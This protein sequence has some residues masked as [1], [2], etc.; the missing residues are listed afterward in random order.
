MS[1]LLSRARGNRAFASCVVAAAACLAAIPHVHA[2][3]EE[4]A[5]LALTV[6][7]KLPAIASDGKSVA[8]HVAEPGSPA[9]GAA[10]LAIFDAAGKVKRRLPLV[11]PAKDADR[12]L[13]TYKAADAVLVDGGYKRMG[14]LSR[15]GGKMVRREK[16]EDPPPS[17][18]VTLT[19]GERSFEVKVTAGKM[20]I[21]AKRGGGTIGERVVAFRTP[22]RSCSSVTGY[23]VTPGGSGYDKPS[24]LLALSLIV[25]SEGTICFSHEVVWRPK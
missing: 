23:A 5:E 22:R 11:S 12:S 16:H 19:Q 2:T 14:H 20:V 8:M 13:A 9:E 1:H 6:L 7:G 4:A 10:S 18:E 15:S 25:D 17:C 3:E 24:G 21:T